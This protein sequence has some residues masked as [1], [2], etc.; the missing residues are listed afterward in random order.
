MESYIEKILSSRNPQYTEFN[1]L[2]TNH[3][4]FWLELIEYKY[5]ILDLKKKFLR[6]KES[7]FIPFLK[8]VSISMLRPEAES[9]KE[10]FKNLKKAQSMLCKSRRNLRFKSLVVFKTKNKTFQV[11]HTTNKWI[12]I[13][14]PQKEVAFFYFYD[15]IFLNHKN[16]YVESMDIIKGYYEG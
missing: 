5:N 12:F 9:P 1:S 13:E 4:I 6:H 16:A 3:I 11:G 10:V 14:L 2:E 7:D 15:K 8:D